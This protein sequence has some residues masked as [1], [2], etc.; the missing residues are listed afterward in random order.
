MVQKMEIVINIFLVC[1]KIFLALSFVYIVALRPLIGIPLAL[2]DAGVC[3][4]LAVKKTEAGLYGP[5]WARLAI[6]FQLY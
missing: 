6:Y 4:S 3:Y 2:L 1:G 5:C